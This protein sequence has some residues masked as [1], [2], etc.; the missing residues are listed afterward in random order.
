MNTFRLFFIFT[1]CFST[2][3]FAQVPELIWGIHNTGTGGSA[4][5]N[6]AH[7]ASNNVYTGG[8]VNGLVDFEYGAGTTSIQSENTDPYIQKVNTLGQFQWVKKL[9]GSGYADLNSMAIDA[10]GN[11]YITGAF[12]DTLDADPNS[13]VAQYISQGGFDGYIVKLDPTGNLVWSKQIGGVSNDNPIGLTLDPSGNVLL[14]GYFTGTVDFDPNAGISTLSSAFGDLDIFI[15]KLTTNGNF[16]WAKRFGQS[17]SDIGTALTTDGT[18][19]VFATG[20]FQGTTNFD[21]GGTN[22]SLTSNG[23][24][25]IY[26]LKLNALGQFQWVK[27]LGSTSS[28]IFYDIEIDFAGNIVGSGFHSRTIDLDPGAGT[29]FTT[30]IANDYNGIVVK[31]TVA[32]DYIWGRSLGGAGTSVCNKI[33]F[34]ATN[35]VYTVGYFDNAINP[36]ASN[37]S[38][39]R[40]S[41]GSFDGFVQKWNATGLLQWSRQIGSEG[42]DQALGIDWLSTN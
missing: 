20:Y 8:A 23:N 5:Y 17:A 7:D 34:D 14:T 4:G 9:A 42:L 38:N 12:S 16:D 22:F 15:L 36:T 3:L 28:D 41:F 26:I 37:P 6:V 10:A 31:L 30:A 2:S 18:G 39:S 25:D 27:Q 21:E 13:G 40:T 11:L 35:S 33:T 1:L 24:S 19:N 32:G 29:D